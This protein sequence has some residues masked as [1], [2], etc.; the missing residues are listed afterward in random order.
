[1]QRSS[2]GYRLRCIREDRRLNQ[3][4]LAGRAGF[5]PSAICHFESGRR[6]PSFT[7]LKKLA[8]SLSVSTDFLL[9][10]E[11]RPAAEKLIR[12]FE[13]LTAKDQDYLSKFA[14][15][16]AGNPSPNDRRPL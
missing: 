6:L 11:S 2:F 15:F 9:A 3:S 10:R 16:L 1:M 5:T 12:T 7:S 4:E 14:D 8:A 13:Q